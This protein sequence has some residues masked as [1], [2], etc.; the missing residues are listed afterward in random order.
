M[1]ALLVM[2]LLV[3]L[4]AAA[5]TNIPV[6]GSGGSGSTSTTPVL[7]SFTATASAPSVSPGQTV[8]FTLTLDADTPYAT[9]QDSFSTN[10]FV[11][12]ST[13]NLT[14]VSADINAPSGAIVNGLMDSGGLNIQNLN[15]VLAVHIKALAHATLNPQTV[16]DIAKASVG[17]LAGSITDSM[18]SSASVGISGSSTASGSTSTAGIS[19]S[20]KTNVIT[21]GSTMYL[22]GTWSGVPSSVQQEGFCQEEETSIGN[23][24]CT[25]VNDGFA[26]AANDHLP[27]IS[28][29]DTTA[30]NLV[31]GIPSVS[32]L[33][34]HNI[35]CS[36][37]VPVVAVT[38]YSPPPTLLQ[39][40]CAVNQCFDGSFCRAAGSISGN[41]T[42]EE[43]TGETQAWW[44]SDVTTLADYFMQNL[45][46]GNDYILNCGPI[47]SGINNQT[48][49]P[50]SGYCELALL[51]SSDKPTQ[52]IL[53]TILPKSTDT[54][55]GALDAAQ[56]SFYKQV[57]LTHKDFDP[58]TITSTQQPYAYVNY[59][60]KARILYF[61]SA[62]SLPT[63]STGGVWGW[64]LNLFGL[65]PKTPVLRTHAGEYFFAIKDGSFTQGK[66][67]AVEWEG[68][69]TCPSGRVILR[70]DGNSECYTPGLWRVEIQTR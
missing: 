41:F 11:G 31:K 10:G 26:W 19:S 51:D 55:Q 60:Q 64:L 4:A 25:V 67:A 24:T 50:N 2:L 36:N 9:I 7:N 6:I 15:G 54:D 68:G 43:Q 13:A 53:G 35:T 47:T 37:G 14:F 32:A 56:A 44:T 38:K 8:N 29:S 65:A 57:A 59:D 70:T 48:T 12:N 20:G 62:D 66:Q 52:I 58:S 27:V 61:T 69:T 40:Q 34:T 42:C 39:G 16:A 46:A 18:T 17:Q 63:G 1:K 5:G 49:S 28:P 33:G 22:C 30:W 45:A 23:F 3:P 21:T